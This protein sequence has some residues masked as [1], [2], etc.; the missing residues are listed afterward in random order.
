VV[1][2]LGDV[3]QVFADFDPAG[4]GL[5]LLELAG[6]FAVRLQVESVLMAGAAVHPQ[7]DATLVLLA[8]GRG[9]LGVVRQGAH[10]AGR[11][12]GADTRCR[13]LH[14]LSAGQVEES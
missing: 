7:Q 6:T 10:P 4:R 2:L 14:H 8:G 13:E 3:R 11:G 5:D 12:D 1:H 9:G